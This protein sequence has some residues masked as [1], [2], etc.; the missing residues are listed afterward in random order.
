M[1]RDVQAGVEREALAAEQERRAA[2]KPEIASPEGARERQGTLM[3]THATL[4]FNKQPRPEVDPSI[5]GN[6]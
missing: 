4:Y 3:E 6:L 5:Y 2:I 1:D